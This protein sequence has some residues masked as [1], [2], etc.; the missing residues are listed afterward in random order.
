MAIRIAAG[1]AK[2]ESLSI[3]NNAFT[4]PLLKKLQQWEFGSGTICP[5]DIHIMVK[6]LP[7]P[8]FRTFRSSTWPRW[9][10]PKVRGTLF[11][12]PY[13]KDPTI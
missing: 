10:L 9:E 5:L 3:V 2:H 6:L 13:D 8:G 11:G 12:G 4:V 1:A 7:L